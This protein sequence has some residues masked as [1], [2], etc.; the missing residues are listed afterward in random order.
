MKVRISR[1]L[2]ISFAAAALQSANAQREIPLVD[3]RSVD[4]S[5]VVDL[6]YATTRNVAGRRLYPRGTRALVRPEVAARLAKAQSFLKRYQFRLKIWDAYRPPAVQVELWRAVGKNDYVANPDV[7]AGSLHSW[8]VAVDATLT[9]LDK[10]RVSMP[11]D[12]DNFTP[13]AMWRYQ[14]TDPVIRAHLYLLQIAMHDAGFLGLR[15]EW[16]HFTA[17]DW[18]QLL[19]PEEAKRAV[20]MFGGTWKE[21][22]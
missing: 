6:R 20:Q 11:T 9:D 21:N 8:G 4:R 18:K 17:E 5:I 2:L 12:Y 14:G 7:G 16:W 15:T 1:L 10:R 19:P 3:V 13:A 22:R